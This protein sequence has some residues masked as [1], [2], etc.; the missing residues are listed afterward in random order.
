[1]I[2]NQYPIW[3]LVL[4]LTKKIMKKIQFFDTTLRDGE[5]APGA[6]MNILQKKEI[7]VA[8]EE[9]GVDIIEAGFPGA[10]AFDCDAVRAVASVTSRATI[11]GLARLTKSDI[12][13]V[14]TALHQI[15][16]RA[17]IHVFVGTSPLHRDFKLKK[18]KAEILDL[19]ATVVP[20]AIQTGFEVQF[21]GEDA[22]R[23]EID[24]L[25]EVYLVA[26]TAG[27]RIFNIPD[28][29]GYATP[30]EIFTTVSAVKKALPNDAV[31]SIHCHDDLGLAT[32]NSLTALSAGARQVEC[33]INGIGERAGN[34]ALEEIVMN[35][36]V[37]NSLYPYVHAIKTKRIFA[38]SQLV[39]KA[40]NMIVAANKSIVGEN[41]FAHAAGIHQHGVMNNR[42][43][44]EI[45]DPQSV[46]QNPDTF[47]LTR[48]SGKHA[49]LMKL[50][51]LGFTKNEVSETIFTSFKTISEG[52]KY[53]TDEML[54][55]LL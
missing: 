11:C 53:V 24:Y 52:H 34:A 48:H 16:E 4:F 40:S 37:R 7:A 29:V 9:L 21:S 2:T 8:L 41:A 6:S 20:Y 28:T 33:C 39:A 47:P 51:K 44:Y 5:Q 26:Y 46:G 17:R 27:V 15:P 14:Q 19:V 10:S 12:D 42:E 23:T 18:T 43:T 22:L 45:I 30:D 49:L 1:M 55:T 50:Q 3:L 54:R 35:I 25:I 36:E 31:I 38:T 32:I 13:A